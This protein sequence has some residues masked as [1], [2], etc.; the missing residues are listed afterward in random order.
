MIRDFADKKKKKKTSKKFF[1]AKGLIVITGC[2]ISHFFPAMYL[3]L[4][5]KRRRFQNIQALTTQTG[6][7]HLSNRIS[8]CLSNPIPIFSSLANLTKTVGIR[9]ESCNKSCK[10]SGESKEFSGDSKR[11]RERE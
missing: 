11:E 3:A 1:K 6:N 10:K 8:P 9:M 4:D 7:H 5:R 2:G